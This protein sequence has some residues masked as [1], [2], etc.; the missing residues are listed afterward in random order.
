MGLKDAYTS[1]EDEFIRGN[2]L[3]MTHASIGAV[4]GRSRSSVR[5]RC[6]TLRLRKMPPNVT[7]AERDEIR[8]AYESAGSSLKNLDLSGLA[9]RLGRDKTLICNE[10]RK[11]GL[12]NMRRRD[13]IDDKRMFKGDEEA[14]ARYCSER[15]K[16][17]IAENGHPRGAL[18]MKHS[19]E[20]KRVLGLKSKAYAARATDEDWANRGR[21]MTVT[22]LAKNGTT[23]PQHLKGSAGYSRGAG[24][25]RE[26]LGI[27]VR[28]MWEANYARYLNWLIEQGEIQGWEYEPDTFVFHGVTRG[29]ITYMPDFK[30]TERDGSVVYHEV[31][32]WMD[33]PSKTKLKRM[34][35]YYPDVKVI[36]I[37]EAEYKAVSKWKG[38]IPNWE[39]KATRSKGVEV[40]QD[41]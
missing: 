15:G 40:G 24:G 30:V 2:Y 35:K 19:D 10:A 33:G 3:S 39:T 34:A 22:K 4:I 20:T 12:T 23:F 1:S 27:Y 28:S 6:Y 17:W 18:G 5:N 31:K 8:R 25:T 36:V 29:A 7:D 38:L 13:P 32:G 26:D 9:A 21:K 11:M 14:Y 16:K 41:S 37:G